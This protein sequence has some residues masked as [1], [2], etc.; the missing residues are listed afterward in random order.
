MSK[1]DDVFTKLFNVYNNRGLADDYYI[2][3]R[4][5][6]QQVKDIMYEIIGEDE[7]HE[8]TYVKM[9]EG[10]EKVR[11]VSSTVEA[12][13]NDLRKELRQKVNEL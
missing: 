12:F 10:V 1:L 6:R 7:T 5:A 11:Q 4:E 3:A 9:P 2:A 8:E 13:R